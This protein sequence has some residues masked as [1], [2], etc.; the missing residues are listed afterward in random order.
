MF[1]QVFEIVKI[2]KTTENVSEK[3]VVKPTTKKSSAKPVATKKSSVK[4]VV[5]P[6]EKKN[7]TKKSNEVKEVKKV[8]A[9]VNVSTINKFSFQLDGR[10]DKD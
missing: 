9:K 7:T 1:I 3:K 2:P 6:V 4:K 10:T 8:E 5:K